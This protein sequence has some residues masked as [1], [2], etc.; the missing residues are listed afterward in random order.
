GGILWL[1]SQ[2]LKRQVA[3]GVA[4]ASIGFYAVLAGLQPSI[5]R[6]ALMGSIA[7]AATLLGRQYTVLFALFLTGFCMLLFDPMLISDLGFQLSFL[8]TLGIVVI[9]PLVFGKQQKGIVAM[10]KA[11]LAIT[12]SA[13][14]TTVPLLLSAFSSYGLL[15]LLT[16]AL[17]LWTVPIILLGG[18]II[19]VTSLIIPF[20]A[21]ILLYLLYPLL[22]FFE[23]IVS[24]LGRLPVV[25]SLE[26]LPWQISIGYYCILLAVILVKRKRAQLGLQ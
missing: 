1:V 18:M 11:D 15:S 21:S 13:Q 4:I 16:N 3:V 14:I 10:I 20:F 8:A 23:Y 22:L 17:V 26:A 9:Q 7:F 5:V 24:I 19:G 2:F 12:F 6:A 25:V